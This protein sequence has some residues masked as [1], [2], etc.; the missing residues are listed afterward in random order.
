MVLCG[1]FEGMKN[2]GLSINIYLLRS[3]TINFYVVLS[4]TFTIFYYLSIIY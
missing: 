1:H 4:V 2:N 3:I